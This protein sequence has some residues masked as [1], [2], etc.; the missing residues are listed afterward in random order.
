MSINRILRQLGTLDLLENDILREDAYILDWLLKDCTT[1]Q[2]IIW[3]TNDYEELGKGYGSKDQILPELVTGD[4]TLVIQPRIAKSIQEQERRT[5]QKAEVFTPSWVCN[6]QNNLVDSAWFRRRNAGFNQEID[7]DTHSWEAEKKP[8]RFTKRKTWKSYVRALRMEITC[9]EAPYIASRYDTVTGNIIPVEERIGLLDRKLRVV[10]ENTNGDREQWRY[11]ALIA[12][13]SIYGYE[14]Q[15]DNVLLARENILWT[16]KD[17]YTHA[18]NAEVPQIFFRHCAEVVAWNIWQMDGLK[19]V[20]P[21][22][23]HD[24]DNGNDFF[25]N[26]IIPTMCPG[27]AKNIV[28][29]HNGIR[30]KI[31]SWRSHKQCYF[32]P[33]FSFEPVKEDKK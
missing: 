11:W 27:C 24:I 17:F 9:G 10:T 23:C 14:Y 22:S 33:P 6:K 8:V 21:E 26:T 15:G 31:M 30:C 32:M 5:R 2:N 1:G 29:K 12:L 3:A 19:Y 7:G 13:Q 16:I 20:I 28:A 25:G 4:C 18:F